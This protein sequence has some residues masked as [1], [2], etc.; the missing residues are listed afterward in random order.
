MTD[1]IDLDLMMLVDQTT[2]EEDQETLTEEVVYRTEV[3]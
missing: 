2:L 1:K 3:D